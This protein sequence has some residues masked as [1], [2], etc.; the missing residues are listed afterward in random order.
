MRLPNPYGMPGP[1]AGFH[2]LAVLAMMVYAARWLLYAEDF[3]YRHLIGAF[4]QFQTTWLLASVI[5]AAP[6]LSWI[7]DL[8]PTR[9]RFAKRETAAGPWIILACVVAYLAMVVVAGNRLLAAVGGQISPVPYFLG[10]AAFHASAGIAVVVAWCAI[11]AARPWM[12]FVVFGAA[13]AVLH[14]QSTQ[15]GASLLY[16]WI[17]DP[18]PPSGP[19]RFVVANCVVL[20]G[21]LAAAFVALP[22]LLA[23]IRDPGET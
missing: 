8:L 7:A 13:V 12:K 11:M 22:M 15:F 18:A 6:L 2:I 19:P 4:S 10:V 17:F 3:S 20:L 21:W 14:I 9:G 1:H 23:G 5:V 16:D